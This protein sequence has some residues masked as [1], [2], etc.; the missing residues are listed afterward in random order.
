MSSVEDRTRA[1]MDAITSQV[2]SAPPLPLPPPAAAG[3]RWRAP[4]PWRRWG[5][6]LT[7]AAAAAAVIALAISLVIVRDAGRPAAPP[8]AGSMAGV[9]RYYVTIYNPPHSEGTA[10]LVGDTFTGA[11][12][13]VVRPP[14]GMRFAGIAAAADDRTFV[15]DAQPAG[16]ESRTWYLLRIAPG[17]SSPAQLTKQPIPPVK[18]V[19]AIALSGSGRQLAVATQSGTGSEIRIYSVATG[20]LLHTWSTIYAGAFGDGAHAAEQS[21]ALA[22]I[23]GD[24]AVAFFASG[25]VEPTSLAIALQQLSREGLSLTQFQKRESELVSRY[26]SPHMEMTWRRLDVTAGDGDLM[27]NSEVIWSE[28]ISQ[29]LE[30]KPN[31]CQYGWIQ[32]ISADG[33]TV[34]CGSLSVAQ[35]TQRKPISWRVAWLAYSVRTGA[36]RT[37]YRVIVHKEAQPYVYPL[38]AGTSGSTIIGEWGQETSSAR[39]HNPPVGVISNGKFEQIPSPPDAGA[40]APSVT[41]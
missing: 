41:W 20:N 19:G 33:T 30:L 4:S 35:G 16:S 22:W 40:M 37:L 32:G 11:K 8:P 23:D 26:G 3:R 36:V 2:D 17:T 9:P 7:P 6:W 1:A 28:P 24:R 25:V 14:R 29:S 18:G 15:V 31:T 39:Q 10:L 12:V 13:A 21:R 34:V 5:L 38:W 27:A